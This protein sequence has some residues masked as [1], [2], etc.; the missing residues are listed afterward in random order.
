M[1]YRPRRTQLHQ[2]REDH[3]SSLELDRR[4]QYTISSNN[5]VYVGF[6]GATASGGNNIYLV[7]E[8]LQFRQGEICQV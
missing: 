1:V 2:S 3:S 5:K 8:V 4:W 6:T 7:G